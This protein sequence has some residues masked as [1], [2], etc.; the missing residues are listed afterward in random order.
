[1]KKISGWKWTNQNIFKFIIR[2]LVEIT[3]IIVDAIFL[4]SDDENLLEFLF[5]EYNYINQNYSYLN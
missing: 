5:L 4:I 2:I 3:G 1:L